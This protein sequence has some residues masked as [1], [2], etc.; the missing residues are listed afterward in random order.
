MK[1]LGLDLSASSRRPTGYCILKADLTCSVG[2]VWSDEEIVRVCIES[3]PTIVAIDSPLTSSR[4]HFRAC[5]LEARRRGF[6]VL[7]LTFPAMRELTARGI[8]LRVE[9]SSLGFKV[10]EVFPTGAFIAL[11]LTP[12]KRSLPEA[13]EGLRSLGLKLPSNVSVHEADAAMSAYVAYKYSKG[14]VELLGDPSEGVIVIP[15]TVKSS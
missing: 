7:P 5:D 9:L 11:S 6:K 14:E 15:K 4:R 10:I 12:P 1:F 2:L 13:V 3:K 8:K